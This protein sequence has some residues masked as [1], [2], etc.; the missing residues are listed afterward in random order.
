MRSLEQGRYLVRL[1]LQKGLYG[2]KGQNEVP[3]W[4]ELQ[5]LGLVSLQGRV[6]KV[7][8]VV[9]VDL[10]LGKVCLVLEARRRW[11]ERRPVDRNSLVS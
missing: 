1:A 6:R 3:Q 2:P 11:R 8:V 4:R 7:T 10:L 9:L 5:R